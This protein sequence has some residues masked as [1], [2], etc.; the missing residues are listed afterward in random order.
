MDLQ[1]PSKK[2]SKSEESDKGSISLY[3]DEQTIRR[4]IR[5]AVTDSVGVMQ[6]DEENQPGLANLIT[7]YAVIAKITPAEVVAKYANQGYSLFKEDLG[8]LVA[9][10]LKDLQNRYQEIIPSGKL[11]DILDKG[12][13]TALLYA[14]RKMEKCK[15]KMGL[16]RI[17]K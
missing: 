7:I 12:R 9:K 6:F 2:M 1:D 10:E 4:K 16:G 17:R 11:D 15:R 8:L 3:D 14:S 5:S 13:Q